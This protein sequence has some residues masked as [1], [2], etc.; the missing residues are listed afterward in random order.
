MQRELIPNLVEAFPHT[1]F[2]I[3]THS[4]FIVT[5]SSEA[6]VYALVFDENRRA[7]SQYLETAELSGS[8][9]ETL[10][11]ILGVPMTAPIWVEKKLL[12]IL[13][14]YKNRELTL[15]ILN[16]LKKELIS[17]NLGFLLPDALESLGGEDAQRS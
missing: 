16:E 4:P 8:A 12:E 3:C 6:R 13:E 7:N 15:D 11:E 17:N 2:I 9:N 5:S 10:R 14:R 1:Q